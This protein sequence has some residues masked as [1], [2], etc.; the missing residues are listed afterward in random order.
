[1]SA[2]G[3]QLAA[4]LVTGTPLRATRKAPLSSTSVHQMFAHLGQMELGLVGS[5]TRD[6]P[7][8]QALAPGWGLLPADLSCRSHHP[9]PTVPPAPATIWSGSSGQ[10]L[11][12]HPAGHR[13]HGCAI[14]PGTA[15]WPSQPVGEEYHFSSASGLGRNL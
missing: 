3:H 11:P 2:A 13:T 15:G 8:G 14:T 7:L 9:I 5:R 1:M 4:R 6:R 12:C 10:R